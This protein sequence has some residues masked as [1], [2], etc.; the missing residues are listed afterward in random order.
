MGSTFAPRSIG[1]RSTLPFECRGDHNVFEENL[2]ACYVVVRLL[3][4]R[5]KHIKACHP[6]RSRTFGRTSGN[7]AS[8]SKS[9]NCQDNFRDLLRSILS[10]WLKSNIL[11]CVGFKYNLLVDPSLRRQ[12]ACSPFFTLTGLKK[13]STAHGFKVLCLFLLQ[14]RRAPLRMTALNR[15]R[16]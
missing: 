15:V 9:E 6:E 4:V 5:A 7:I 13:G 16:R 3:G 2:Q 10:F 14:Y 1:L 11:C 8:P 12:A